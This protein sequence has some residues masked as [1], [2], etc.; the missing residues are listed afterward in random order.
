M[1]T[2]KIAAPASLPPCRR[3]DCLPRRCISPVV[4]LTLIAIASA[5]EAPRG[6]AQSAKWWRDQ[7]DRYASRVQD[8]GF[9][10]QWRSERS[11]NPNWSRNVHY[12]LHLART[13]NEIVQFANSLAKKRW[14]EDTA[15]SLS[16]ISRQKDRDNVREALIRAL[17]ERAHKKGD[18]GGWTFVGVA[19]H[20]DAMEDQ[21]RRAQL[22]LSLNAEIAHDIS[23]AQAKLGKAKTR[24]ERISAL[25]EMIQRFIALRKLSDAEAAVE[26]L[27]K[28]VEISPRPV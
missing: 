13:Q 17:I 10:T 22:K 4:A 25:N 14:T 15:T 23:E 19:E 9:W 1:A 8:A 12:A 28:V 18:Q 27:L 11:T 24:A 6:D 2:A 20:I 26:S 5:A 7:A 3:F 21:T 16:R